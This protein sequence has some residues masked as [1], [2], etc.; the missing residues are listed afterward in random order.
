MI[1]KEKPNG[2]EEYCQSNTYD[3]NEANISIEENASKTIE[4]NVNKKIEQTTSTQ[5]EQI[6]IKQKKTAIHKI[7]YIPYFKAYL[8]NMTN[9]LITPLG[10]SI[11]RNMMTGKAQPAQVL[12]PT[13]I[14]GSVKLAI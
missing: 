11:T 9:L 5:T 4:Q 7:A 3:K 6:A 2:S 8:D 13:E 10:K 12:F 1:P 14:G